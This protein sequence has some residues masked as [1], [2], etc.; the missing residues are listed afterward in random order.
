MCYVYNQWYDISWATLYIEISPFNP[1]YLPLDLL[2]ISSTILTCN[3]LKPPRHFVGMQ[4][5]VG[6]SILDQV[7]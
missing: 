2:G 7:T 3:I 5:H 6:I 4:A 1:P